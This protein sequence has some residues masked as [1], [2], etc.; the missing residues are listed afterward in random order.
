M[1]CCHSTSIPRATESASPSCVNCTLYAQE[2]FQERDLPGSINPVPCAHQR[3]QFH[4]AH[5]S[6]AARL[7][8]N[9]ISDVCTLDDLRKDPS[10]R[11][12]SITR[13]RAEGKEQQTSTTTPGLHTLA[14]TSALVH[15]DILAILT[16][17]QAW[18]AMSRAFK[19]LHPKWT[20]P[21][22]P[23]NVF[24]TLRQPIS[25]R[26]VRPQSIIPVT[27]NQALGAELAREASPC[28]PIGYVTSWLYCYL[29]CLDS[30]VCHGYHSTQHLVATTHLASLLGQELV[31]H[32]LQLHPGSERAIHTLAQTM[33]HSVLKTVIKERLREAE[34][35]QRQPPP[36]LT[37]PNA[38]VQPT[39]PRFLPQQSGSDRESART[40]M[41]RPPL[42][43]INQR[44]A[45]SAIASD[46]QPP[47]PPRRHVVKVCV[48]GTTT[49]TDTPCIVEVFAPNA[50]STQERILTQDRP[51]NNVSVQITTTQGFRDYVASTS[52]VKEYL[53]HVL[54]TEGSR[55]LSFHH[56][57][58][59]SR[60]RPSIANWI[61]DNLVSRANGL[62]QPPWHS[63]WFTGM[64]IPHHEVDCTA[65]LT[66]SLWEQPDP[67]RKDLAQPP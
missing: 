28:L 67:T 35:K 11:L 23:R 17:A 29:Q 47:L 34:T 62:Y 51:S 60:F 33:S 40:I 61:P 52:S 45:A 49:Q 16:R 19:T 8:Y 46:N 44:A 25:S 36:V 15:Q 13:R 43:Q 38:S 6:V 1:N 2:P 63:D 10:Y 55:L 66:S 21:P 26:V 27:I 58:K 5:Y 41:S 30:E 18:I 22:Q 53:T 42:T 3:C 31:S 64:L 12:L 50:D 14:T 9:C 24:E 37:G 65:I 57:K 39:F 59:A 56:V 4:P 7:G 54:T 48:S 32:T 20:P